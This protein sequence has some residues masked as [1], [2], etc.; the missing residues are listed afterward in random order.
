M[1][2][3]T[4]YHW[5]SP[6]YDDGALERYVRGLADS[7]LVFAPGTSWQYSNIGF[8]VLADLIAKVSGEPFEDYVQRHILTPLGMG[9]STLL[10][11]RRR[12]V[13]PGARPHPGRFRQGRAQSGLSLQSASRRQFDPALQ[14]DGHASLGGGELRRGELE[15]HRILSVAGID[16]MWTVAYDLTDQYAERMRKAGRPMRYTSIGQGLGW[17]MFTLEGEKLVNHSGG[18]VGFRSDVLLWPADSRAPWL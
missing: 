12:F 11:D 5:E 4:D 17:R 8:E 9:H 18:D 13:E 14:P 1:P 15:G 16:Q 2:D 3:V 10:N 6:E 7:T